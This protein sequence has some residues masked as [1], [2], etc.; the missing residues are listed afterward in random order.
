MSRARQITTVAIGALVVG[1]VVVVVVIV[2]IVVILI[3]V[4]LLFVFVATQHAER[5]VF[6]GSRSRTQGS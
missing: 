1:V 3:F 2:F 5:G 4:V 6:G